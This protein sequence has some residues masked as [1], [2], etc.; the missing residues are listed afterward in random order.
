MNS[1]TSDRDPVAEPI[2][3]LLD[4]FGA[5]ADALRF[6]EIDHETLV[7]DADRVRE[8]AAEVLRCEQALAGA[9]R[10]LEQM[11]QT[12][13]GRSERGLAYARIYAEDEPSLLERLTA[14]ELQPRRAT[15]RRS[16]KKA[17]PRAGRGRRRKAV[18]ADDSVTEL[19]FQG[20]ATPPEA[21]QADVA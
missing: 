1:I 2:V 3:A 4:V 6:P 19:P 10:S 16:N 11:Q 18:E 7:A 9:R 14:L 21:R 5:H 15:A 12:L 20:D 13:L 8:A 17:P